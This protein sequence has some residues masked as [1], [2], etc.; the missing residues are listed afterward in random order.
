MFRQMSSPAKEVVAMKKNKY[1]LLSSGVATSHQHT[2]VQ[3]NPFPGDLDAGT[4]FPTVLA[5]QHFSE[6]DSTTHLN[7]DAPIS[8]EVPSESNSETTPT[9]HI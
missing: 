2:A 3:S 9:K 8:P 7:P 1:N 4:L 6:T 5:R